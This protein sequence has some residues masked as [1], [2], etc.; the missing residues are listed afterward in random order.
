MVEENSALISNGTWTLV[1][2]TCAS[3]VV[4]CKWIFR[5]KRHTNGTVARYKARLVAKGFNQRPDLDY[6]E[7][8]SPMVKPTTIRLVLSIAVSN[9]WQ[10]HQLRHQQRLPSRHPY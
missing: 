8:F 2:P 5:L 9:G 3:N 1:P 4:G 7:T 6:H 10:L